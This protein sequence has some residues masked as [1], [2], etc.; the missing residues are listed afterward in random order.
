[1]LTNFRVRG[2]ECRLNSLTACKCK[3]QGFRSQ[4][5]TVVHLGEHLNNESAWIEDHLSRKARVP[6]DLLPLLAWTSIWLR[7]A[8]GNK[9]TLIVLNV[10]TCDSNESG[11]AE[12]K[13]SFV[14]KVRRP[15]ARIPI[16]THSKHTLHKIATCARGGIR[17]PCPQRQEPPMNKLAA[18][19]RFSHAP[20]TQKNFKLHNLMSRMTGLSCILTPDFKASHKCRKISTKTSVNKQHINE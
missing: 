17:N 8:V 6:C 12:S 16:P 11:F 13:L 1:M 7:D 15:Q 14:A 2:Y 9:A 10:M 19:H 18:C 3:A 5:S 20:L 4:S